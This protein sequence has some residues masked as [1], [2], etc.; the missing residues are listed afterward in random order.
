MSFKTFTDN[1]TLPASDI[2]S[3]LANSGLVYIKSQTIAN[4]VASVTVSSAFSSD[5]DN[6]QIVLSGGS[7]A[8]S[9]NIAMTFGAKVTNYKS[10]LIY[11]AWNNTTA[12]LGSTVATSLV[13]AGNATTTGNYLVATVVTPFDATKN[14]LM[15]SSWNSP[16][17]TGTFTGQTADTVSYTAFTLTIPSTF[18]GGTITVY[19]YRK[20]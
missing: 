19:G 13:Y 3:F 1:T 12:A 11:A 5:Y 7:A 15:F 8:A 9:T 6:Y 4:G 10:Q 2:N 20:A 14:T 17:E 16:T 18:T